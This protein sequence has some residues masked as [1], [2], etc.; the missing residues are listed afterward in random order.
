MAAH[1]CA[2]AH[3]QLIQTAIETLICTLEQAET[4]GAVRQQHT[5]HSVTCIRAL[6]RLL[7]RV[8]PNVVAQR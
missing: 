3:E 7:T 4:L 6:E 5:K 8:H 2:S 1:Q